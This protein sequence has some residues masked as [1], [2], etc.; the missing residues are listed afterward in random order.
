MYDIF[1]YIQ[2]IMRIN[3]N[4]FKKLGVDLSDQFRT[5]VVVFSIKLTFISG[6]A[7]LS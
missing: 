5:M 3:L 2:Q 6:C 7:C 1:L 4:L